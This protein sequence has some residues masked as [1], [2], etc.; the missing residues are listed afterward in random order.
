[1]RLF[2]Q[3][4]TTLSGIDILSVPYPEKG[5]LDLSVCEKILADDIVDHYR[6]L[7][8]LGEDSAAMKESGLAA[9][10]SFNETYTYQIN[11]VYR[12]NK[13]KALGPQTWPGV[14]CQPFVFGKGKVDW[15]GT[16]ELK[17]KLDKL[18]HEQRSSGLAITRIARVLR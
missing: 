18:L 1:M 10:V 3:K 8:R 9:L 7:I 2:T 6:D 12:K 4:A 15:S 17:D 11:S 5:T 14:I 16:D 13:L